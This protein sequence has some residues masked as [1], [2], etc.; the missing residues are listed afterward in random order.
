MIPT[1]M[2]LDDHDRRDHD[3]SLMIAA[4]N[5]SFDYLPAGM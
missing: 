1:I 2:R 3:D 5:Q 4:I